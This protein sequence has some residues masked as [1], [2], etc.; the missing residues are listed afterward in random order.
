MSPQLSESS[1]PHLGSLI[2]LHLRLEILLRQTETI[3]QLT[4]VVTLS[5]LCILIFSVLKCVLPQIFC[6]VFLG[7]WK[8]GGI[9]SEE[10]KCC[11]CLLYLVQK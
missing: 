7:G 3:V 10:S 8:E 6:L 1:V 2:Y 5:I 4:L 9:V 11:P